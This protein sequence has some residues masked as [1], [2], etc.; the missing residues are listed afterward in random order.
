MTRSSLLTILSVN[1]GFVRNN[2]GGRG[3]RIYIDT[4]FIFDL[5]HGEGNKKVTLSQIVIT[6]VSR[7]FLSFLP[8]NTQYR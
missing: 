4:F 7:T 6:V 2:L 5:N 1:R 3:I 8:E